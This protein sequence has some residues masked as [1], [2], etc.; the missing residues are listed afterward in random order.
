MKA[1]G[2]TVFI[3]PIGNASTEH[4]ADPDSWDILGKPIFE[5]QIHELSGLCS[6][7]ISDSSVYQ[8]QIF[9]IV[10]DSHNVRNKKTDG[11]NINQMEIICL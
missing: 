5:V 10:Y 6:S 3:L 9:R 11:E 8:D 7:V 2:T 4:Q 1:A